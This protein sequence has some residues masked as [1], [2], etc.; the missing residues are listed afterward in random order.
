MSPLF[1]EVRGI[2]DHCHKTFKRL[3]KHFEPNSHPLKPETYFRAFDEDGFVV[4]LTCPL[5][6]K[7]GE[8]LAAFGFEAGKLRYARYRNH[9]LVQEE[10]DMLVRPS[11]VKSFSTQRVPSGTHEAPSMIQ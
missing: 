8:I 4:V 10:V 2:V 3:R 9:E 11:D 5:N 7:S 6:S 1:L